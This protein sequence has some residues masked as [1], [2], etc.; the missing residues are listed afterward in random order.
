[1]RY[2]IK[3]IL[4]HDMYRKMIG[5]V[6]GKIDA[7]YYTKKFVLR[8]IDFR[9]ELAKSKNPNKPKQVVQTKVEAPKEDPFTEEIMAKLTSEPAI[10]EVRDI[11]TN[12]KSSLPDLPPPPTANRDNPPPYLKPAIVIGE[13]IPVGKDQ[14][15]KPK[16]K[17]V[18][19]N[20]KEK[21]IL[22]EN[23]PTKPPPNGQ[24][25]F[26]EYKKQLEEERKL[27]ALENG[28]ISNV[29]VDPVLLKEIIY[30]EE[31]PTEKVVML[32]E[33]C[34]Y[35]YNEGRIVFALNNLREAKDEWLQ[36][37]AYLSHL[38]NMFFNFM[39]GSIY[40]TAC[41]DDLAFMSYYYC[42]NDSKG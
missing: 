40:E 14:K 24:E 25:H 42:Y 35:G 26:F 3:E 22:F 23:M 8:L 11:M 10:K 2:F 28:T 41:R 19:R 36:A 21:P 37:R 13:Q 7:S 12:I 31:P 39:T 16:A 9:N 38:E 18:K 27:F 32:L 4:G 6:S 33:A 30:P 29:D 17:P 20:T 1:L 34:F 5:E 15:Q